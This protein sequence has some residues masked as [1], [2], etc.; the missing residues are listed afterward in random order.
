MVNETPRAKKTQPTMTARRYPGV[1]PFGDD[2]IQR[3]LFR[4]RDEEKYELFQLIVAERL[5]L[6]FARSGIGKSSLIRAGL[7]EPLR[8]RSYFPI[9]V[10]VSGSPDGPL[11]SLYEGIRAAA[12]AANERRQI[13]HEPSETDW[14]KTSLW[15]FF[16][17]SSFWRG[18]K[19]LFPV[20][21]IDQ[22][23]ELFTLYS[24]DERKQ[25]IHELSDLVR[26]TRP[27][28]VDDDHGPALSDP[29]PEVKVLLA[30]REDFYANL[31]ELRER[32][33]AI[34]KAPF[35]LEPLSREKAR[36]AIV[37]PAALEGENFLTPPFSWADEAVDNVLNFL[38]EQQLGE[39]KTDIGKDVE[40]FQLQLICQHVENIVAQKNLGTVT[41]QDLGSS[42]ALKRVLSSF[43]EDSLAAICDKFT[44][45]PDL[46][47]RLEKLCE[48][49]FITGRGRRL[50]R[51]ES[52]IMQEDG[53][54]PEILRDMV[55]LRLLRK[56][57]R[58]GDNYYELTHDTLIEPIQ[59]SRLD[60]E[61]RAA[62]EAEEARA[63][64]AQE[65]AEQEHK[66]RGR[67]RK[68]V[69][70]ALALL[71]AVGVAGWMG[72]TAAKK[73]VAAEAVAKKATKVAAVEKEKAVKAKEVADDALEQSE[74]AKNLA[75]NIL[76]QAS[77]ATLQAKGAT[78]AR[79][80]VEIEAELASL[81]EQKIIT[82]H[83]L[84]EAKKQVQK[85]GSEE[86]RKDAKRQLEQ[87]EK[88][89][90]EIE[91][92]AKGL[93][94]DFEKAKLEKANAN[95][96]K[97]V[98]S[99]QQ[100]SEQQAKQNGSGEAERKLQE[101]KRELANIEQ[102]A[103]AQ[104]AKLQEVER[105][106]AE[107]GSQES[108]ASDMGAG[109]SSAEDQSFAS[110]ELLAQDETAKQ[111]SEAAGPV[112]IEFK[113][114]E[115][116]Y[117]KLSVC[118]QFDELE[119]FK[120]P[121]PFGPEAEFKL[122]ALA[123]LNALSEKSAVVV[124]QKNL[125]AGPTASDWKKCE[126][127]SPGESRSYKVDETVCFYAWISSP[128]DN[129]RVQMVI[130]DAAKKTFS[131]RVIKIGENRLRGE[132]MGYRFWHAKTVRS[133]GEHEILFYNRSLKKNPLICRSTFTVK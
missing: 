28:K 92:K 47:Q 21:I 105:A 1:R 72:V 15:H 103:S 55:E 54:S 74:K 133:R 117:G 67:V 20:L 73:Q 70:V 102:E 130:R 51:E 113:Q 123:D 37:E 75:G 31:E 82:E 56:E 131:S 127:L 110:E 85:K 99:K 78:A 26:G 109:D 116:D 27:R 89:L 118:E 5:V 124:T 61:E 9:V 58:V 95:V 62:R 49:G 101:V 107:A 79:V 125:V 33:P 96:R 12:R 46:R 22:F 10:R 69:A 7:L 86:S 50:L 71:V 121:R 34:Y 6:L 53:V 59:L 38:S 66:L 98:E 2:E 39:G 108:P 44:D 4:G 83:Q 77:V 36:R 17:T 91:K 16:K 97:A 80:V 45:E 87:V 8:D 88:Q 106:T 111:R 114:F 40:P 94:A 120:P 29:P 122:K 52:T 11:E 19:L 13:V 63:R 81:Q 132:R 119:R 84:E 93:N 41:A 112:P 115:E 3:E 30:L 90:E 128:H 60:R 35:R 42:D 25:F 18:R 65:R 126:A 68:A 14:N 100:E 43:Y 32:I 57:P 23:E 48:Y 24:T 64:E 129:N 76:N 104:Q